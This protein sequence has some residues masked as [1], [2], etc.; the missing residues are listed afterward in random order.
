LAVE[1]LPAVFAV[2]FGAARFAP[3]ARLAV[4]RFLGA[5]RLVVF[6]A[7]V[8]ERFAAVFLA[9]F[10][11]TFAALPAAGFFAVLVT[12][13]AGF[14][15]V[16]LG[17]IEILLLA[18]SPP[19]ALSSRGEATHV[20]GHILP[21]MVMVKENLASPKLTYTSGS[22]WT[23]PQALRGRTPEQSAVG[24]CTWRQESPMDERLEITILALIFILIDKYNKL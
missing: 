18:A 17:A 1:R 12:F 23:T 21:R 14:F 6:F 4:A 5:A 9:G 13:L 19:A 2:R 15:A 10:F 22:P 16:F 11:A 3:V 7:A 8:A 20:A 24:P